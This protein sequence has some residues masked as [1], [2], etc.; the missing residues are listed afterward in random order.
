[1]LL[2]W[3]LGLLSFLSDSDNC[4]CKWC[5]CDVN[6]SYILILNLACFEVRI[7]TIRWETDGTCLLTTS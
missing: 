6:I 3:L 5:F 4:A 2:I 7:Q 1:M